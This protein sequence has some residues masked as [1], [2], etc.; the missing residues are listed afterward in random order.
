M[1]GTCM[2]W[3]F[4]LFFWFSDPMAFFQKLSIVIEKQK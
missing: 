3:H 4:Y 1:K 2:L